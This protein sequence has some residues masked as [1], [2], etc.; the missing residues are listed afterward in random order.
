LQW[1]LLL[2]KPKFWLCGIGSLSSQHDNVRKPAFDLS[3]VVR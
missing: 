3:D 2:G 1:G